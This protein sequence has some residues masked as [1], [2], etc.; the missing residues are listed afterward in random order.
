M[1]SLMT[2][3]GIILLAYLA[4]KYV[5]IF[6]TREQHDCKHYPKKDNDNEGKEL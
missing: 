6:I 4:I 3:L 2:I 5:E 1:Q